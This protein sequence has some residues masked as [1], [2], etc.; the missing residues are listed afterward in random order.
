MDGSLLFVNGWLSVLVV[1]IE[2]SEARTDSFELFKAA[3][4]ILQ[5]VDLYHRFLQN[6]FVLRPAPY[7]SAM[8]TVSKLD[9]WAFL[10]VRVL[11][12]FTQKVRLRTIAKRLST[13]FVRM[14]VGMYWF[15]RTV[16]EIE[17]D[18]L[19]LKNLRSSSSLPSR[20]LEAYELS[21]R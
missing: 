15:A 13:D 18:A 12:L 14:V 21:R 16:L 8:V 5:Q 10:R 11:A 3:V 2:G 1:P 9:V 7:G 19:N 4:P 20:S 6:K 17:R